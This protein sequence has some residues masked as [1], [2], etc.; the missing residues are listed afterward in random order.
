[1]N[2]WRTFLL[3]CWDSPLYLNCFQQKVE[4]LSIVRW[5]IFIRNSEVHKYS[6][7]SLWWFISGT[8][9]FVLS[10]SDRQEVAIGD[11]KTNVITLTSPDG[12]TCVSPCPIKSYCCPSHNVLQFW[13]YS[14]V[15]VHLNSHLNT[16]FFF[17]FEG[18]EGQEDKWFVVSDT[19]A[20]S[21]RRIAYRMKKEKKGKKGHA[22]GEAGNYVNI[23]P[24]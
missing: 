7:W 12:E 19:L 24:Q 9:Q 3:S 20:L 8:N 4:G 5:D 2:K 15:Q 23:P 13:N 22:G 11:N 1:M 18:K 16:F 10:H 17:V 14:E 21:A 6:L